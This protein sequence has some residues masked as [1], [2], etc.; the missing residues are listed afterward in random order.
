MLDTVTVADRSHVRPEAPGLG[1]LDSPALGLTRSL[2]PV[3]GADTR[4]MS[5]LADWVSNS[6]GLP[7][8][9]ADLV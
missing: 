7:W 1:L 5:N 8:N 6:A 3:V 9:Y 2:H 4:P